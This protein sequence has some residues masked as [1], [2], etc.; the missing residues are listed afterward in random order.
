[1]LAGVGALGVDEPLDPPVVVPPLPEP[2]EEEPDPDV[3]EGQIVRIGIV[4][5]NPGGRPCE[6]ITDPSAEYE[7]ESTQLPPIHACKLL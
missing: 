2:D 7:A 3:V 4:E 6:E 1:M 5:P